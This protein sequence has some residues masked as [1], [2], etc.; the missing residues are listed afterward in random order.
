V[1]DDRPPTWRLHRP[2]EE[3]VRMELLA[4]LGDWTS[5]EDVLA[6]VR[7]YAAESGVAALPWFAE[8]H[9]GR[10]AAARGDLEVAL[11]R[12][13]SAADGFAAI[14][15]TWERARTNLDLARALASAGRSEDAADRASAAGSV[16]A[17][18]G[19]L[20]EAEAARRLDGRW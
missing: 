2:D 6:E 12:L 18:L 15:A 11:A 9:E 14:E 20:R 3:E 13:A 10:A 17:A 5:T 1:F 8:R 19:A 4:A 7:A 16:F